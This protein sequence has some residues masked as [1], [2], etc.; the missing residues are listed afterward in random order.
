MLLTENLLMKNGSSGHCLQKESKERA[1][2]II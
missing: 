1:I 2:E